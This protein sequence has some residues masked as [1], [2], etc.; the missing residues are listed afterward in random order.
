VLGK[1]N[2]MSANNR[3]VAIVENDP[4]TVLFFREAL[5]GFSGI[6]IFTFQDPLLALEHFQEFDYAYVLVISDFK[7]K[8][9]DGFELLK[10]IKDINPFVRTILIT[11]AFRFDNKIFQEYIKKKVINGFIQKPISLHDFL[12]E[13]DTQ[14]QSYETQKRYPLH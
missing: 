6:T 2:M 10:S 11:A 7:M 4:S 13:V 5:K 1:V 14:L 12:K 9:L 8:G 3:I